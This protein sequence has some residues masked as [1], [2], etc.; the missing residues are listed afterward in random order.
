MKIIAV[1]QARTGSTRFPGKI[2]TEISGQSLLELHLQRILQSRK[3]D[4]LVLATTTNVEDLAVVNIGR[5]INVTTYCGSETDV[6]DRFYQAVAGKKADYI[7]RLTSD[8]PLIDPALIDRIIEYT[9]TK[10]LDY[11]SNTLTPTYPDGQDV[12]VFTYQALEYAWKTATLESEREHVTPYIWKNSSYAGGS[13]FS[14]DNFQEGKS[15]AHLRM[16]V[17]EPRDLELIKKLI[18]EI[19]INRRW[20]EYAEFLEMNPHLKMLN[21]EITRNEGY[22]KSINKDKKL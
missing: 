2:L 5:Q 18:N 19:G 4:E 20:L 9:I 8:C 3:I 13:I 11:C 12:E 16:T 7:V 6:L 15:F 1:T 10:N 14:S 21:Q 17:D 22:T